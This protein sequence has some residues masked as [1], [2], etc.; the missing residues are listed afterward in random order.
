MA[1]SHDAFVEAAKPSRKPKSRSPSSSA[2]PSPSS[3]PSPPAIK[4]AEVWS[5]FFVANA[6]CPSPTGT[7]LATFAVAHWT[8]GG[9]QYDYF[10]DFPDVFSSI[11]PLYAQSV[12]FQGGTMATDRVHRRGWALLG[13]TQWTA[14]TWVVELSFPADDFNSSAVVG[15]CMCPPSVPTTCRSCIS[16]PP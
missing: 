1:I 7:P 12:S 14:Q 9:S 16:T 8:P 2:S 5:A 15:V 3:A 6:T 11:A 10:I 4:E 13:T